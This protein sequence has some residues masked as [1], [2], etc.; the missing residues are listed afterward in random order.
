MLFGMTG[1]QQRGE[2][3]GLLFLL[4]ML[5]S[6]GLEKQENTIHIAIIH[7]FTIRYA[8]GHFAN[9]IKGPNDVLMLF[10]QDPCGFHGGLLSSLH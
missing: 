9:D 4:M 10:H 5:V 6:K 2:Q 3:N 8:V 7:T 1:L